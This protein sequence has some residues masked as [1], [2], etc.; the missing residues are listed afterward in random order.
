M[1]VLIKKQFSAAY[2]PASQRV[3]KGDYYERL[4]FKVNVIIIVFPIVICYSF[5]SIICTIILFI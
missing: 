3:A 4:L 5:F 1:G 2:H